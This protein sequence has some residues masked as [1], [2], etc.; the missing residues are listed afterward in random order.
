MVAAK[1]GH[2]HVVEFLIEKGADIYAK[3]SDLEITA[4]H[5]ATKST[6]IELCKLLLDKGMD[7]K[8]RTKHDWQPLHYA[9]LYG[10]PDLLEFLLSRGAEID[11]TVET[12]VT[13]L[14]LAARSY[15]NTNVKFLLK[16]GANP[17]IADKSSNTPVMSACRVGAL[18]VLQTLIELGNA[19]FTLTDKHGNNALTEADK[20]NMIECAVYLWKKGCDPVA[21]KV[22]RGLGPLK[23][24]R[25]RMLNVDDSPSPRYGAASIAIGSKM[26]IYGGNG[27]QNG[28]SHHDPDRD[29]GSDTTIEQRHSALNDIWMVDLE[30]VETTFLNPT[31]N[32]NKYFMS[33]ERCGTYCK[34]LDDGFTVISTDE[35]TEEDEME[36]SSCQSNIP[37]RAE[38]G[39][40]YFEVYIVDPGAKG[41]AT[42][43]LSDKQFKL[44]RIPGWIKDSYGYHGDDGQ[45]FHNNGQGKLWGPRY[46]A[47]D[48]IGCGINFKTGEVFF[49]KNGEWLGVAY[50]HAQ[51]N[52]YY[53][54]VGFRNPGSIVK[55][56]FGQQ[57]FE[58]EFEVPTLRWQKLE[59]VGVTPRAINPHMFLLPNNTILTILDPEFVKMKVVGIFNPKRRRWN[60]FQAQGVNPLVYPQTYYTYCGNRVFAL[61][62]KQEEFG[63]SVSLFMLD[64]ETFEWFSIYPL[65]ENPTLSNLVPF[66][67]VKIL[68]SKL[69]EWK[70]PIL[71]SND[72]TV[73]IFEY[74]DYIELNPKTLEIVEK[75]ASGTLPSVKTCA[76]SNREHEVICFGGWDELRRRQDNDIVVFDPRES[77]WY[78]PHIQG[79]VPR[80][81][82]HLSSARVILKS[83]LESCTD[84]TTS[85]NE[86]LVYGF[87][88]NGKNF[89][90]DIDIV[91]LSNRWEPDK[92]IHNINAEEFDIKFV[93]P[94][95]GQQI[96]T[97]KIIIA[98]RSSYFKKILTTDEHKEGTSVIEIHDAPYNLFYPMV[99]YLHSDLVDFDLKIEE[100]RAFINVM[101]KYAPEH[102]TRVSEALIITQ[103]VERSSMPQDLL[104]S[105]NNSLWSD[106]EFTIEGKPLKAH[107][108]IICERSEYF[109]AMLKGG[110]KESE[111]KS[112]TILDA[113]YETFSMLIKYLYTN[114]ID[115]ET[116][117]DYIASVFI[118]SSIYSIKSLN[119]QLQAVM[120]YN[121]TVENVVSLLLLAIQHD[122]DKLK[123][124]CLKFISKNASSLDYADDLSRELISEALNNYKTEKEA[125]ALQREKE[126]LEEEE[127]L[128]IEKELDEKESSLNERSNSDSNDDS[129]NE[130]EVR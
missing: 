88:W 97:F 22:A 71:F 30:K 14:A 106:I 128:R 43:G 1:R 117:G 35:N 78:K 118:L 3:T 6:N 42:L 21:L 76:Y 74:A 82:N 31:H 124:A 2:I 114:R 53:P 108:A 107:K 26:Y 113:D 37:F 63:L 70:N 32:K 110:L 123:R 126:R 11:A 10:S 18:S 27:Y 83:D 121:L 40:C 77:L 86:Y 25:P 130:L 100:S 115:Y 56:N 51:S 44:D 64:V 72:S 7:I 59:T 41:I 80:P 105:Y 96:T 39:I 94:S 12:N 81:R 73:F 93:F 120:T 16:R 38:D 60:I 122:A 91:S 125:L 112:I 66:E 89:I 104:W 55:V 50:K 28:F 29:L 85:E 109:Q 87:G 54:T 23:W 79:C 99:L 47:G 129:D 57:P 17:N 13:A 84:Y 48:N 92:L 102:V 127:I 52:E 34:V 15:K 95:T 45:V 33:N 111:E 19:D 20:M 24:M 75:K 67:N 61:S 98:S 90:D 65:V 8:L 46:M 69:M 5:C 4:L 68:A 49:T 101:S 36:P 119:E 58:F 116:I 9:S 62:P 103:L